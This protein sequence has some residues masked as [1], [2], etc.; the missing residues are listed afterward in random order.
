MGTAGFSAGAAAVGASGSVRVFTF[1]EERTAFRAGTD[2]ST[3]SIAIVLP[4]VKVLSVTVRFSCAVSVVPS[5]V[6]LALST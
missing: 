2:A 5:A 3:R 1:S 6:R 4:S